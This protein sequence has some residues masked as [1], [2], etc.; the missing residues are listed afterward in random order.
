MVCDPG[1]HCGRHARRRR[2]SG[3]FRHTPWATI[4]PVNIRSLLVG[5]G[6]GVIVALALMRLAPF[7]HSSFATP[8]AASP[9]CGRDTFNINVNVHRLFPGPG[10]N[11]KD[12]LVAAIEKRQDALVDG[13]NDRLARA[14]LRHE[15][16]CPVI[17]D[18]FGMAH[19]DVR[20]DWVVS[21]HV[22]L[23]KSSRSRM[24]YPSWDSG[25]YQASFS[26]AVEAQADL[27]RVL[28]ELVQRFLEYFGNRGG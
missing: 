15:F 16:A 2:A 23:V 3:L 19:Q 18:I 24:V 9:I 22:Q 12:P 4:L 25:D 6:F 26:S 10:A 20:S 5:V 28:T 11:D 13:L 7:G 21:A 8:H 1:D 14:G 17:L 27:E